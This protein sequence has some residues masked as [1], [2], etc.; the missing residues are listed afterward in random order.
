MSNSGTDDI[1]APHGIP[2]DLLDRIMII[3]L[4]PYGLEDM[5]QVS[6]ITIAVQYLL[7]FVQDHQNPR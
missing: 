3:K 2:V 1:Q 4:L 6:R 5:V 7:T